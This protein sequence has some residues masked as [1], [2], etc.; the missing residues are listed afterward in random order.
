MTTLMRWAKK[1]K[2]D[3]AFIS[4]LGAVEHP[5][6]G[7]FDA[8]KKGYLEKQFEGEFEIAGLNG[9]LGW[10]A[11]TGNPVAH[12]H[13]V[14]SGPNFLAFGGHLYSAVVSGT[15]EI[16]VIPFNTKLIRSYKEELNLKLLD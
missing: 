7:Y 11:E 2:L 6:L 12:V 15:V 1:Q 14:V 5:H 16:S 4:G 13:A 9:N 8:E 3:G 10:D